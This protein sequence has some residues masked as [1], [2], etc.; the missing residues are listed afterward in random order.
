MISV[1]L[2]IEKVA[3]VLDCPYYTKCFKLRDTIILFMI[4]QGPLGV[5]VFQL[6]SGPE[7]L[8]DTSLEASRRNGL[9]KSA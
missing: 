8:L 2:T 3:E 5:R 4:Q 7:Q 1:H 9:V 6:L